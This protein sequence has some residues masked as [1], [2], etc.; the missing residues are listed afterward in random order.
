MRMRKKS[1]VNYEE[2]TSDTN[3]DSSSDN[4]DYSSGIVSEESRDS[5]TDFVESSDVDSDDS[6]DGSDVEIT[7][8]PR[9]SKTALLAISD[10]ALKIHKDTRRLTGSADVCKDIVILNQKLYE[11]SA[12]VNRSV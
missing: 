10:L 5:E 9:S 2:L 1:R 8:R 3:S 12:R 6:D 4:S 11:L 7:F